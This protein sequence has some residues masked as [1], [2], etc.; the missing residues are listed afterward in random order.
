MGFALCR[1][2]VISNPL[3]FKHTSISLVLFFFIIMLWICRWFTPKRLHCVPCRSFANRFCTEIVLV[4]M[5]LGAGGIVFLVCLSISICPSIWD[6]Y[7]KNKWLDHCNQ[8]IN[9]L[10]FGIDPNMVKDTVTSNVW[11]NYIFNSFH[12]LMTL[13][14]SSF[15]YHNVSV[16]RHFPSNAAGFCLR[17]HFAETGSKL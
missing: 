4:F 17:P 10:A 8:Q 1:K 15:S 3:C 5:S 6:W 11:N 12:I 2:L 13:D 9:R 16:C 7:L 14:L